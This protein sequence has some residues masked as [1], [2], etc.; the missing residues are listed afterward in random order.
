MA[1]NGKSRTGT[2]CDYW[3]KKRSL[4][5]QPVSAHLWWL[6]GS[7]SSEHPESTYGTLQVRVSFDIIKHTF[8]LVM[9][10]LNINPVH[11]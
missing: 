6:D 3:Q 7:K 4:P 8:C 11:K 1:A 9:Y 2:P 5:V 10:G